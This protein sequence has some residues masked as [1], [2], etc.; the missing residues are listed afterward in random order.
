LLTLAMVVD[1]DG[2]PKKSKVLPGNVSEPSTLKAFLETY[3]D[4]LKQ[5]L[6]LFKERPTVVIDA[7]VGTQGNL[8]MIRSMGFH[9]ITMSRSK[10]SETPT[11]G[12]VLIKQERNCTIKAK[13]IEHDDGVILYCESSARAEKEESMKARFQKRY[14]EGLQ[15]I[16]A[17]LTKKK[18]TKGYEKVLERLGRLREKYPTIAQ[19]YRIEVRQEMGKV[20]EITWQIDR[21][22]ELRARFSGS[23]YIRSSRTDLDEKE[24][25]SLYMM[26]NQL[27]DSF[28]CLKSELGLRP[29]YHRVTRRQEAHLFITVL[30]YH[31]LASIQ[32]NLKKKGISYQW[33]TIRTRLSNQTRVTT[34]ITNDK[35]QRI[36]IR[37]TTDPEPFYFPIYRALGLPLKP[38]KIKRAKT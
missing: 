1:E 24:L 28:R 18:G 34:S 7:G 17:S 26:L 2:F 4:E 19:F 23:Y 33:D 12:L 8:Q 38:L 36:H 16:A 9:Y 37:Q 21:E 35:G 25:W 22:E 29:V 27:E 13:R 10:L 15:N 3:D 5:K 32:R 6:P 11:D 20:R 31:L 30:A 14:E